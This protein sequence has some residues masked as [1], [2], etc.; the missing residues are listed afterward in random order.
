MTDAT[1]DGASR[2][3]FLALAAATPALINAA[4]A[5]AKSGAW[6]DA[7]IVNALG[8]LDNPNLKDEG[9]ESNVSRGVRKPRVL[10]ARALADARRSGV[11]AINCTLGYVA[12]GG[13]PYEVTIAS[14]AQYD[15]MVRSYPADVT[16]V[17]TAGDILKAKRDRKVGLI[18]GFQNA[19]MVADKLERV[20]VFAD[21]GVRV[22]QLTYNPANHIGDGSMAPENRGLTAFGRQVVERL[23]D[24]RIMVDLSHSGEQTCLEAARVSRQPISINHTGCRALVDLPRNK[25]DAELKLVAEK[26][27]FVGVYFMPFLNKDGKVRAADIVAHI[28]HALNVCGEDHV[29]IGTDGTITQIDDMDAYRAD[30]AKEVA[31]RKARGIGAT[32]EG[33]ETYPFAIDMRGPTQFYDLADRLKARGHSTGRIEKILG[34]NFVRYAKDVWGA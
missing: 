31:D 10:D 13:D 33:P 23:N 11:T 14:I 19:A 20:D 2:R 24:N 29:G 8:G 6:K 26:G 34:G 21:L 1:F 7:V 3:A 27:G 4:P 16:K 12:G 25:T 17:L 30:L 22:I 9:G 32:G 28:E 15:R 18:Y 5:A